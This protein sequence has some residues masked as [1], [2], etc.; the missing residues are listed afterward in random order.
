VYC[1]FELTVE[2]AG[3]AV[4]HGRRPRSLSAQAGADGHRAAAP[5]GG[6]IVS[7]IHSL[8]VQEGDA[9][10][11]DGLLDVSLV[12]EE[13]DAGRGG[14]VLMD[15][16]GSWPPPP[17]LASAGGGAPPLSGGGG[18]WACGASLSRQRE[19]GEAHAASRKEVPLSS[20]VGAVCT[21][22]TRTIELRI[23][24][25]PPGETGGLAGADLPGSCLLP[26]SLPPSLPRGARAPGD[27]LRAALL[28]RVGSV[29]RG[30]RPPRTLVHPPPPRPAADT[31]RRQEYEAIH[32][33]GAGADGGGLR[34]MGALAAVGGAGAR[35][36]AEPGRPRGGGGG[37]L[38]LRPIT[39]DEAHLQQPPIICPPLRRI[40]ESSGAPRWPS[41]HAGTGNRDDGS[42]A[43]AA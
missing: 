22:A 18:R 8:D 26:P 24:A 3:E 28:T 17:Q 13:D 14:G 2:E 40:S 23:I 33:P 10:S 39:N 34:D 5:A 37:L 21:V 16:H 20:V 29:G 27:R 1:R 31:A 7:M 12:D 35:R 9:S 41:G 43:A 38:A 30:C 25:E 15:D 42:A 6:D 19:A 11:P 36:V 32:A 4:A